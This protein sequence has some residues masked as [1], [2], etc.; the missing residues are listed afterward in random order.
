MLKEIS[1]QEFVK[2][3]SPQ[4]YTLLI[5][6]YEKK[7]N[8]TGISWFSIVSWQPPM[9]IVSIRSS[10][11]GYELLTKNPDFAIAFPAKKQQT[12]AISCGQVSGRDTDKLQLTGFSLRPASKING[13]L[14][15]EAA[16][17]IECS[18]ANEFS[19]G[20]HQLILADVLAMHGDFE[21][22]AH[23]YT[24]SYTEFYPLSYEQ[25]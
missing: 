17:V 6:S 25:K 10:R 1:W 11:Y 7:I 18:K 2:I 4:Y 23:I 22:S 8:L 16:A 19:A 3:S 24:T 13:Y 20:D 9:I 12:G 21:N 5:T 14:L 15:E